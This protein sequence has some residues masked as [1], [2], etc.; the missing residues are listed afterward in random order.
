MYRKSCADCGGA[1]SGAHPSICK[2]CMAIRSRAY[3]HANKDKANA[4]TKKWQESNPE[5]MQQNGRRRNLRRY[6]LSEADYA[7]MLAAQ[8]GT[9]AI[10]KTDTPTGPGGRHFMV[11]HSHSTGAVRGLVCM[12][13][14]FVLGYSKESVSTLAACIEYLKLHKGE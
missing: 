12:H 8:A 9:C 11:D 1:H 3:Y 6:G 14:N 4:A 2:P 10:C 13:C 7:A 5:R